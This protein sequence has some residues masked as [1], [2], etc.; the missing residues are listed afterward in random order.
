MVDIS[1]IGCTDEAP[2]SMRMLA[3]L[4]RH[5]CGCTYGSSLGETEGY[6]GVLDEQSQVGHHGSR[7]PLQA[8]KLP[9]PILVGNLCK[10]ACKT[11]RYRTLVTSYSLPKGIGHQSPDL[12]FATKIVLSGAIENPLRGVQVGLISQTPKI[13]SRSVSIQNS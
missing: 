13:S 11:S 2:R 4:S 10:P 8:L 12:L 9:V 6:E 7:N 5:R 3:T 1:D